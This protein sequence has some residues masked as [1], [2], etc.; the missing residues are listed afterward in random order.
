MSIIGLL[1]ANDMLAPITRQLTT[2]EPHVT[3]LVLNHSSQ[4]LKGVAA[5]YNRYAY[6]DEKRNAPELWSDHLVKDICG[7]DGATEDA[8]SPIESAI[9]PERRSN[10]SVLFNI[11]E[12][13]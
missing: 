3:E 4:L 13:I 12:S 7:Y 10:M 5:V 11:S 1:P 6:I 8:S 2:I 9:T